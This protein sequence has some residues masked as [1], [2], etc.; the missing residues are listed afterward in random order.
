[1]HGHRLRPVVEWI[2]L[3]ERYF[4]ECSDR[5]PP[6]NLVVDCSLDQEHRDA[7]GRTPREKRH[8]RFS[9]GALC[10]CLGDGKI[11]GCRDAPGIA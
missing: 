11:D 6:L 10:H 4:V 1:M 2:M 8:Q 9:R 7:L 5:L 3:D